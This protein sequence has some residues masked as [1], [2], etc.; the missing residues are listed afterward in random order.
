M[1]A[2]KQ[3][4]DS[5]CFIR[6]GWI[7]LLLAAMLVTA[8]C[9]DNPLELENYD[10]EPVLTA[11]IHNGEAVDTIY[12]EWVGKFHAPYDPDHLGVA[13]AHV[14][15]FPVLNADGSAAD[16]SGRTLY[17]HDTG[18]GGRYAPDNPA[19]FPESLV[20][21]RMKV[22]SSEVDIHAETTVPDTFSWN[23]TQDGA[24]VSIDP[25]TLTYQG[26]RGD[27]L[28]RVDAPLYFEWSESAGADGYELGV[29]TL[30]PREEVVP[31]DTT[32][33]LEDQDTIDL[34]GSIPL[35]FYQ[36]APDYQHAI[37][38]VGATF[39]WSGSTRVS[40]VAGSYEY[41]NYM[42]TSLVFSYGS[43]QNVYT[44]VHGG[45]GIFGATT[46]KEIYLTIARSE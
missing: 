40:V 34:L 36:P 38:L 32:F 17:F 22:K 33:D 39:F 15:M 19:F 44:N 41:Y 3:I 1:F 24:P 29:L 13:N 18:L 14:A 9:D 16:S 27:T 45:R 12:V 11:F 10:P 26:P 43:T 31:L 4:H 2:K 5:C 37:T 30:M 42:F 25:T 23:I 8:G 20:R 7:T 21:Y 6:L 28:T 46:R 35:Y